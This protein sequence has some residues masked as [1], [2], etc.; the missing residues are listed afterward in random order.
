VVEVG[1]PLRDYAQWLASVALE[2]EVLLDRW[3]TIHAGLGWDHAATPEAGG[4]QPTDP[5][6]AVAANLRVTRDLG[7]GLAA[8]AAAGRRSRFP[9][10]REEYS[11]ALGRFVINPDLR[12]ERQDQVEAGVSYDRGPWQFEATAFLGRLIDGIERE[13]VD[14]TRFQRVNRG[15]I[16]VPGFEVVG[17]WRP[18]PELTARLQHTVLDARVQEDGD[19]RPAEDRPAYLSRAEVAWQPDHGPGALVAAR[20][21]GPRWSADGT[22]PGGLRRLPAGVLW[23]VRA[24]WR[25][26]GAA[27]AASEVFLRLDNVLDQRVDDQ[28]GL[29]APG[30]TLRGGVTLRR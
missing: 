29:P 7:R 2:S 26:D 14:E 18:R 5:R 16:E 6:N 23:D 11:G 9:S 20:V 1:G 17:A 24:S 21:T 25:W 3:W 15:E 10:L 4:R 22:A 8:H 13:A 30:R 28:T 27:G 12:A 19:D